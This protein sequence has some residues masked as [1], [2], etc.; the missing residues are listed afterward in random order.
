MPIV[1][2]SKSRAA[3]AV[4]SDADAAVNGLSRKVAPIIWGGRHLVLSLAGTVG[5]AVCVAAFLPAERFFPHA[6]TMLESLGPWPDWLFASVIALCSGAILLLF[7]LFARLRRRRHAA[8]PDAY[9]KVFEP[10]PVSPVTGA[11]LL[12]TT[13]VLAIGA[14]W[15]LWSSE[16]VPTPLTPTGGLLPDERLPAALSPL[17]RLIT[18]SALASVALGAVALLAAATLLA[19]LCWLHFG[20]TRLRAV[21]RPDRTSRVLRQALEKASDIPRAGNSP[22]TAIIACFAGFEQALATAGLARAPAD[23][24]NEF[25]C[26]ASTHFRMPVD[27]VRELAHLFE[28]ARFSDRVMT[29][30]DREAACRAL[31]ILNAA[32]CEG[33]QHVQ[34]H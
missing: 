12:L 14:V 21:P 2:Q 19:F 6:G 24:A 9:E 30:A 20:G 10:P 5:M 16:R 3:K 1:L 4:D 13:A 17:G 11:L 33:V 29:E 31:E 18:H 32:L 27:A 25:A 28:L 22:D 15:A 7:G 23:T 8:D 34:T 26:K